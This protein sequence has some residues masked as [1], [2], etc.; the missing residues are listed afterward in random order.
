MRSALIAIALAFGLLSATQQIMPGGWYAN[1]W[2]YRAQVDALLDG[3]LALTP[4]PAGLYHDL[5]WTPSGTQQVWGL[6]APLLQVPFEAL[7]RVI[8]WSPLP[9]RIAM[10][11]WIAFALFVLMRAFPGWGGIGAL[12]LAGFT[13]PIVT[14]LR[15]R[16]QV[17]EDA[18]LY[19]YFAAIVLLA[20]VV[21]F[22]RAPSRWRYVGLLAA[23]GA[24]G[25]IRPTVWF[26]GLGT[27]MAATV[28]WWR[29]GGRRSIA[30]GALA[31]VLG[32]AA[33]Y[34]TNVV[35][36]GRGGEFGHSLNVEALPGNLTA[37]RFSYPFERVGTVDAAK[38]L[39]GSLF[40]RPERIANREYYRHGLHVWQADAARWREYY[41][42][43]YNW[44]WLPL[45]FAG[46][47]LG[48]IA[49]RRRDRLGAVLFG[50]AGVGGLPLA[51]FYLHSPSLSSRYQ[52]DLA[53]A[54]VALLLVGWRALARLSVRWA[55]ATVVVL[56]AIAVVMARPSQRSELSGYPLAL[57][58]AMRFTEMS[59]PLPRAF[60]DVAGLDLDDPLLPTLVDSE[61]QFVRCVNEIDERIDCRLPR[62]G[63]D[64]IY[65][66]I[67][68][69]RQWYV[70]SWVGIEQWDACGDE[71]RTFERFT[72]LEVPL[73]VGF[74][75]AFGWQLDGG[76][77]A[78]ATLVYVRDP[79][80]FELELR[81]G[82]PAKVRV[83]IGL[84]HLV[85]VSMVSTARGTRIRFEAPAL[86]AGLSIAFIA[87]GDDTGLDRDR[88][89]YLV[90]SMRW[91]AE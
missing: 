7:G 27:A 83:A 74:L 35:R 4:E 23:A 71:P 6:G 67:E 84:V 18:A 81:G 56:W 44:A 49:L 19:A 80:F 17:Y 39:I 26:Y 15:G 14:M 1:Q 34:A 66:G 50:W 40:D 3:R 42:S 46:A 24:T 52:L 65:V 86:P 11:A 78:P 38:E 43:T 87:F 21:I 73:P 36:F 59:R 51:W 22:A 5:A 32:G 63:G 31:F 57:D 77:V 75:N 62:V 47:V 70:R 41:F 30:I 10:A 33:L 90:R 20:G 25:L 53:P 61:H 58:D 55:T 91:R 68:A 85:P 89:S 48:V 82:D 37:T 29:A 13:P 8:G 72:G 88:S 45:L 28:L 60:A 79:Q 2:A 64:R 76:N 12:L 54:F 9:D 16:C 69:D